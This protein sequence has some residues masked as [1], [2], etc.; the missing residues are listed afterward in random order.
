MEAV[1]EMPIVAV[2]AS[3]MEDVRDAV[4]NLNTKVAVLATQ[5]SYLIE[6][7]NRVELAVKGQA[8]TTDEYRKSLMAEVLH[9]TDTVKAM[10]VEL[11]M[12]KGDLA[13][14]A[15]RT[16]G[17]WIRKNAALTVSIMV[18]LSMFIAVV[19]WFILHYV[20]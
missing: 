12:V 17:A 4:G 9:T 14:L 13:K 10:E 8:T 18:A 16:V 3:V 15:E 5:H 11:E 19:R 7:I 1:L 2:E 6:A 20:K